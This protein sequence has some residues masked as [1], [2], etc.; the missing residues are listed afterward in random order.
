MQRRRL[1]Y[2]LQYIFQKKLR[3]LL[4]LSPA[5][6]NKSNKHNTQHKYLSLRI[7]RVLQY[8]KKVTQHLRESWKSL[9]DE[10]LPQR[11]AYLSSPLSLLHI[12]PRRSRELTTRPH[13]PTVPLSNCF[14]TLSHTSIHN[15]RPR[16]NTENI[17]EVSS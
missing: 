5:K 15:R 17:A 11:H 6:N 7:L 13:S 16:R 9:R 10:S 12:P 1:F 8:A 2:R 3:H 4:V 14:L